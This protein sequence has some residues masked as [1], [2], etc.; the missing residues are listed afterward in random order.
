L[1]FQLSGKR[2]DLPDTFKSIAE[3]GVFWYAYGSADYED[4][5]E[6]VDF[7]VSI[8]RR[9]YLVP[10]AAGILEALQKKARSQGL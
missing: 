4:M 10:V 7:E 5:M 8:E 6:D 3:A 9:A 2:E 1:E